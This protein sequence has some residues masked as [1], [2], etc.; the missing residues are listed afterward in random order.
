VGKWI[1]YVTN[2]RFLTISADLSNSINVEACSLT[3]HYDPITNP[4][5]TR[6]KAGIQE[7]GNAATMCGLISQTVS[8]VSA[9][10][11]PSESRH[12]RVNL[13][14]LTAS[15]FA[16]QERARRRVGSERYLWCLH[17]LLLPARAHLLAAEPG[18]AL[19]ARRAHH[20]RRSL[21]YGP[22]PS[23]LSLAFTL[24]LTHD[25]YTHTHTH[26][27][28]PRRPPMPAATLASLRRRC[29]P[30]SPRARS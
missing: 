12:A 7:C 4:C 25:T 27:Q 8:K 16:G 10:A 17:P 14:Y 9:H 13:V 6:L 1:N 5:G 21:G 11:H 29:G 3:G 18:L 26:T 2:N 20:R 24:S 23:D 30:C 15:P 28:V 19:Q 22:S